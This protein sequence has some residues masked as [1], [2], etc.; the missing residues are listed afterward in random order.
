MA[1]TDLASSLASAAR[2]AGTMRPFLPRRA[3]SVLEENVAFLSLKGTY[4]KGQTNLLAILCSQIWVHISLLLI[5]LYRAVWIR[6]VWPGAG[7]VWVQ[8]NSQIQAP[9]PPLPQFLPP[10]AFSL[11]QKSTCTGVSYWWFTPVQLCWCSCSA[12][13]SGLCSL[14]GSGVG[15][16]C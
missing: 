4:R 16:P 7:W 10:P 8:P 12:D 14:T 9:D 5:L 1:R 15:L 13:G 3:R 2:D 11:I 6:A